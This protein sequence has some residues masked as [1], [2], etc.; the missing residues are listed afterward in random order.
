MKEPRLFLNDMQ[1]DK[2][3]PVEMEDLIPGRRMDV[4]MTVGSVPLITT[5]R[6]Q[7]LKVTVDAT[8]ETVALEVTSLGDYDKDTPL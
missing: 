2:S 3:A 7:S 6:L 8:S 5:Y 4:R 1:L